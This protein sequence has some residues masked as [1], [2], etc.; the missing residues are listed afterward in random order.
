VARSA[1]SFKR[2]AAKYKPQPKVL[3]ICEDAKSSLEYLNDAARYYRIYVDVEVIHCGRTDPLGIVY[4][5]RDKRSKYDEVYC[6]IDRDG[7]QNFNEALIIANDLKSIHVIASYPCFE[8]WLLLHFGHNT[9]PYAPAG[10]KSAADFVL[11]DL[12]VKPG[13]A[14]YTKGGTIGL[15]GKLLGDPYETAKKASP[16]ILEDAKLI[17]EMNPSTQL[18]ELMIKFESLSTPENIS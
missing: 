12:C 13:M 14:G 16:R 2:G 9:K 11:E 5:A 10:K 3:V 15:F 6:V 1:S 4:E 8:F 17:G 7:H 18:H